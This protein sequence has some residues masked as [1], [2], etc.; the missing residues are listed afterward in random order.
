MVKSL[1]NKLRNVGK[2]FKRG[3]LIVGAVAS[4][5]TA[6]CD[7]CGPKPEPNHAPVAS[8]YVDPQSVE[9]NSSVNLQL[10]GTD[11]DGNNDIIEYKVDVD[12]GA[13]GTIEETITSPNPINQSWSSDYVGNVKI[14]GKVIDSQGAVGKAMPITINV[15]PSLVEDYVDIS[16]RLEDCENDGI[17][18]QGVIKVY[19]AF[20]NSLISQHSVN[21]NFSITLDRLV[22][23]FPTGVIIKTISTNSSGN[24]NS[25]VRTV[26][27]SVNSASE[28]DVTVNPIRVVPY[29]DLNKDGISDNISEF[30]THIDDI[31]A[32]NVDGYNELIKSDVWNVGI[33]K[34]NPANP[35]P[36]NVFS[37]ENLTTSGTDLYVINKRAVEWSNLL[38]KVTGRNLDIQLN[39]SLGTAYTL[40]DGKISPQRGW[41]II[42]KDINAGDSGVTYVYGSETPRMVGSA[43]TRLNSSVSES[44]PTP[45]HEDGHVYIATMGEAVTLN[46]AYTI[47]WSSGNNLTSPGIADEKVAYIIYEPTYLLR[48][49]LD[50]ILGTDTF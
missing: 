11:E 20:D 50:N 29:P 25:Y 47:T 49:P 37:G 16:G 41:Q 7:L 12:K 46:K 40:V 8:L 18:K 43:L 31:N 44:S 38:F 9:V 39:P 1:V 28:P 42:A 35:I 48:E 13:D 3:A 23:E 26:T 22:S 2:G 34:T 14:E 24:Q 10:I 5:W 27:A 19:N 45:S 21:G 6:S 4:I 15:F 32:V 33:L 17:A 36:G 30:K